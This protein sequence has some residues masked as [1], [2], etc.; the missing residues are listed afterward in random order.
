M[1]TH[2]LANFARTQFQAVASVSITQM[3]W[4][5]LLVLTTTIQIQQQAA[6][7]AVLVMLIAITVTRLVQAP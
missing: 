4:S 6:P 3:C 5:A 1:S 2:M 7:Y